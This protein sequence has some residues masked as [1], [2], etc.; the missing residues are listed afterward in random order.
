LSEEAYVGASPLLRGVELGC[1]NVLLHRIYLKSNLITGPVVMGVFVQIS[2][3]RVHHC[4]KK[5]I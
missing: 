2:M 1:V 4:Y 5:M 3:L